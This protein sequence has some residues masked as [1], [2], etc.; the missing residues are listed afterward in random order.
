MQGLLFD[1]PAPGLKSKT[2]IF[3]PPVS[4]HVPPTQPGV[5]FQGR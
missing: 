4:A 2:E 1:S 3:E 5:S